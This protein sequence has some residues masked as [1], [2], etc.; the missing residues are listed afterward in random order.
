MS[1]MRYVNSNFWVDPWVVDTLNPLDRYLFIYLFTNPHVTLA[2]VYELS[3]RVMAFET[4]LEPNQLGTML[5]DLQPKVYYQ[6]GWVVLRNGIKNQNY[7]NEKIKANIVYVLGTVPNEI[8]Q[9]VVYPKDFGEKKPEGNKQ[10]KLLD[11]SSMTHHIIMNNNNNK[12]NHNAT[13]S[14]SPGLNKKT[15][16]AAVRAD[17]ELSKKEQTTKTRKSDNGI[18]Y[19]KALSMAEALKQKNLEKKP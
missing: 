16:R 2:G 14:Q 1:K 19:K 4:G 7:K 10:Q 6:D 13:A 11:D 12:Y 18:G 8:L 5:R 9:H 15:Y 17:E 3:L